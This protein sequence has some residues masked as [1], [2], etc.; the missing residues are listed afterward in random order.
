M[1]VSY[2]IRRRSVT[3]P[4]TFTTTTGINLFVEGP[5]NPNDPDQTNPNL[6]APIVRGEDAT[7]TEGNDN[8]VTPD[9]ANRRA[10]VYIV[11]WSVAPTPDARPFTLYLFYEG[12]QVGQLFVPSGVANQLVTLQIPWSV[13]SEHGNGLKRVH[14]AI[15]AEGSTNRQYSPVTLVTVTA[16]IINLAPPVVRNLIGSG[17][18][19]CTSFRPVGP[20]PGNIVVFIPAS[21]HFTVG[22]IVTVHWK[23]YRDDAGMIEV[24]AVAG[25]KDSPPLTQ[26]MVNLGFEVELEDYFTRFKPI[27][28]THDDRLAGSARVYYSIVLASGPVNSSE[29]TP[30]VRGQLV[31]GATGTFCDGTA[32]P[33]P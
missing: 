26:A 1:T 15:G 24:P 10:N 20:P 8:E 31:G 13:I 28:P 9:H 29:A 32:V 25:S 23:G 11:L 16:N 3:Y 6:N 19:N 33:A 5:A 22:M 7:G 21:E 2:L 30:R 17:I 18:I 4:A 27:Q 14:Y 12:V